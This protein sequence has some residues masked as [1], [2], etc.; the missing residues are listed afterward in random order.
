MYTGRAIAL[1]NTFKAFDRKNHRSF[2]QADLN[3]LYPNGLSDLQT[4]QHYANC[5]DP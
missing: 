1:V 3:N 4:G 5:E 2:T